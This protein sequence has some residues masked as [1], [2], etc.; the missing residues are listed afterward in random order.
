MAHRDCRGRC[1]GAAAHRRGVA[2]ATRAAQ[3]KAAARRSRHGRGEAGMSD[4]DARKRAVA[5][6]Y[7]G[8]RHDA[9]RVVAKGYGDVAERIIASAS[10]SGIFVHDAPEL[11]ALLMQVDLDERIPESLYQVVAEL[12]VWIAQVDDAALAAEVR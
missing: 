7:S 6:A 3:R 10:A 2:G 12:L 1:A 5:L 4:S 9:P 8:E 11:V